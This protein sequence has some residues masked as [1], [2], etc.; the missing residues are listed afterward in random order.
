MKFLIRWLNINTLWEYLRIWMLCKRRIIATMICYKVYCLPLDVTEHC[1]L[2]YKEAII[3]RK[4]CKVSQEELCKKNVRNVTKEAVWQIPCLK[5]RW[6]ISNYKW[7]LLLLLLVMLSQR[8]FS[9]CNKSYVVH[10]WKSFNDIK[11]FL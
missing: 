3:P 10:C 8:S 5:K 9:S 11:L 1:P 7:L 6:V 2:H 4:K